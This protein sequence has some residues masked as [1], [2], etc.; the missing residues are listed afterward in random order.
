MKLMDESKMIDDVLVPVTYGKEQV[1][2]N[3]LAAFVAT[4]RPVTTEPDSALTLQSIHVLRVEPVAAYSL[5][6]YH[7]ITWSG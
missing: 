7:E 4:E 3:V 2:P 6:S 1:A 5:A